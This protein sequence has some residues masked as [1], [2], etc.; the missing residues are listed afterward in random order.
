MKIK[1]QNLT[2]NALNWAVAHCLGEDFSPNSGV[3]AIGISYSATDYCDNWCLSGPIIDREIFSFSRDELSETCYAWHK[4]G[5]GR[6]YGQNLLTACLRCIVASRIGDE[7][8]VPDYVLA[9]DA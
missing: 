4:D 3:N 9:L 7:V 6:A 8:D 1:T 2:K 5:K